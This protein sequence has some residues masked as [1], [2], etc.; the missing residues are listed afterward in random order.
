ML[1]VVT[2]FNTGGLLIFNL[3]ALLKDMHGHIYFF[4]KERHVTSI[5]V[6]EVW[7]GLLSING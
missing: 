3:V 4:Y 1:T 5:K 6:I 2:I 7:H